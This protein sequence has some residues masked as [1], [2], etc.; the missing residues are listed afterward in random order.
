MMPQVHIQQLQSQKNLLAK[1]RWKESK[2]LMVNSKEMTFHQMT[3]S[4][5]S[6]R[7]QTKKEKFSRSVHL[8]QKFNHLKLTHSISQLLKITKPSHQMLQLVKHPKFKNQTKQL[9]SHKQ[10]LMSI[11]QPSKLMTTLK[12]IKN[13]KNRTIIKV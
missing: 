6:W 3:L 13:N 8:S 11:K 4:K 2:V 10:F 5:K 12:P 7:N 1:L 9:L